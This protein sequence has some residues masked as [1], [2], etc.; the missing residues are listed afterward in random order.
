MKNKAIS[1][2]WEK[3]GAQT[4]AVLLIL[5][6][7]GLYMLI[8]FLVKLAKK[9]KDTAYKPVYERNPETG[10]MVEVPDPSID[11]WDV[12]GLLQEMISVLETSY[13]FDASDRCEAFKKAAQLSD[14][15]LIKLANA[16]KDK[17]LSTMRED[18]E[19]TYGDGCTFY[20]SQWGDVLRD[21][22]TALN[23][24]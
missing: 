17:K 7:I 16:Y 23:I 9:P 2:F 18:M 19:N 20:E 13:W 10:E 1:Q 4:I 22:M 3:Y 24:P 12:N 8:R 11:N 21:R 5:F 15:Q 14:N 6:M